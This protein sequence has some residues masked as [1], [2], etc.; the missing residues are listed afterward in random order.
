MK[1]LI[2]KIT[3]LVKCSGEFTLTDSKLITRNYV[4]KTTTT[5]TAYEVEVDS[6]PID[7]ADGI[8][9]LIGG[10]FVY[11]SQEVADSILNR[12]IEALCDNIDSLR[13]LKTYS[14]VEVDFPTGKKFIQFRDEF[15]RA[16]L[17][18]VAQAAQ[19]LVISGAGSSIVPYR[20]LDNET[21]L[22]TAQE[23]LSIAGVV[24]SIKQAIVTAAWTHKDTVRSLTSIEDVR[25]YNINE[26]W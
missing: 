6:L 4:D 7:Y 26:G 16:N 8:Y 9:K 19:L 20:T 11:A 3:Q 13:I 18:N 23:M 2:D 17:S 14:D 10:E 15:D 24:M 12:E 1:I 21:Q 25:A 5:A 22:P